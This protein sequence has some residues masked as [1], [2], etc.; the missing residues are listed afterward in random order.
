MADP[1]EIADW[2]L[3]A[4][5][6]GAD[7]VTATAIALPSGGD[8]SKKD[9]VFGLG[10]TGDGKAQA[11]SAHAAWVGR[12]KDWSIFPAYRSRV[13]LLF[14]PP[15]GIAVSGAVAKGAGAKVGQQVDGVVQDVK[16]VA[17][18]VADIATTVGRIG[19]FLTEPGAWDRIMKVA[20]GGGLVF[21]AFAA[22]W[23]RGV[24]D[25]ALN[26]VRGAGQDIGRGEDSLIR[27]A[28][29]ARRWMFGSGVTW[30]KPVKK[31]AAVVSSVTTPK[32]APKKAASPGV[33][34]GGQPGSMKDRIAADRLEKD[35]ATR[36][37]A[38]REAREARGSVEKREPKPLPSKN[39]GKPKTGMWR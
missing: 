17:S 4:G 33:N 37:A 2:V 13:Y 1:I 8:T 32:P 12:G 28:G 23:K 15:A 11:S 16:D 21:I 3:S 6:T 36:A 39:A 22:M 5:W 38:A 19:G 20:I 10:H 7:A 24:I 35:N 26:I 18:G 27:Q 25:P 31:A 14:M 34:M 9:G 29:R 30:G